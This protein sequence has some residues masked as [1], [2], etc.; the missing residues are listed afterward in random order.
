MIGSGLNHYPRRKVEARALPIA[1]RTETPRVDAGTPIRG[2][3]MCDHRIRGVPSVSKSGTATACI[4][5]TGYIPF[6]LFR[7]VFQSLMS[8][9]YL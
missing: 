5:R 1:C 3:S 7:H 4:C 6:Q 8:G 9:C 2:N